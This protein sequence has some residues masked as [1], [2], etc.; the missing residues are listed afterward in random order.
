VISFGIVMMHATFDEDRNRLFRETSAQWDAQDIP[1]G[2][3][4]DHDR[5]GAWSTCKAA[6]HMAY[7]HRFLH[8]HWL[9]IQDDFVPCPRFTEKIYAFITR[10][11]DSP[12][13]IFQ[14]AAIHPPDMVGL[15]GKGDFIIPDSMIAW[16]GSLVL[17]A[18]MINDIVSMANVF[19]GLSDMD[20]TRLSASL[21]A[22]GLQTWCV[23]KSLVRHMGA[24]KSLL[25]P[26][27]NLIEYRTGLTFDDT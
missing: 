8:S 14:P 16:G 20:D 7:N 25:H 9:V 15:M 3:A 23:G 19:D 24:G 10:Y 26:N 13:C 5:N 21:F 2:L 11:P 12:L 1:F 4:L 22:H 18:G 6:W 27:D 17:P